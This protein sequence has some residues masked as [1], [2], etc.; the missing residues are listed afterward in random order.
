V[1][2]KRYIAGTLASTSSTRSLADSFP[3]HLASTKL[4]PRVSTS[5]GDNKPCADFWRTRDDAGHLK[6][7]IDNTSYLVKRGIV[8]EFTSRYTGCR[9]VARETDDP[10]LVQQIDAA[11]ESV[12]RA[13]SALARAIADEQEVLAACVPRMKPAKIT[14]PNDDTNEKGTDHE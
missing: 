3:Q 6:G 11:R 8:Q 14:N 10:A 5:L 9:S 12:A 7:R 2:T 13:R 1:S 4:P